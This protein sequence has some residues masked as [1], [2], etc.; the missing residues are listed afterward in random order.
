MSNVT[1]ERIPDRAYLELVAELIL[2]GASAGLRY[3]DAA[4]RSGH[5]RKLGAEM[6]R[7]LAHLTPDDRGALLN[8]WLQNDLVKPVADLVRIA[9]VEGLDRVEVLSRAE[10]LGE[11]A[12]SRLFVDHHGA[13]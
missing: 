3:V 7:R 5:T 8:A 12:A 11:A 1:E 9:A 13:S 2:R 4:Q 6:D 10:I